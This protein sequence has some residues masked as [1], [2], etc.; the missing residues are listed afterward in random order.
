MLSVEIQHL[1]I[2]MVDFITTTTVISRGSNS[3][4]QMKQKLKDF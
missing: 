4:L 2:Q 3:L 1:K